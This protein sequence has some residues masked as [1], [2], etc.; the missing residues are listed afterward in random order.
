LA[1][2]HIT[3]DEDTLTLRAENGSVEA[4]PDKRG[5]F[6]FDLVHGHGKA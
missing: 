5:L 4:R 2:P 3:I 1:E 6:S